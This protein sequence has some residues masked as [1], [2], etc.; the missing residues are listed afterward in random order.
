MC[1]SALK[2]NR[3]NCNSALFRT[4]IKEEEANL[5]AEKEASGR[6]LLNMLI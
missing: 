4:N 1:L 6:G 5:R 3:H 2:D